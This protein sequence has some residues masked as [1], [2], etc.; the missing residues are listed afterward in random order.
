MVLA[1]LVFANMGMCKTAL[2]HATYPVELNR[3][4]EKNVKLKIT[5]VIH[6]LITILSRHEI[7]RLSTS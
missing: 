7:V 6:Q 2:T 1:P 5:C 4:Q 3:Q